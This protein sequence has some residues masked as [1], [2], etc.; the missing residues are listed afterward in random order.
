MKDHKDIYLFIPLDFSWGLI[1]AWGISCF[2]LALCKAARL[3]LACFYS[4]CYQHKKK[5]KKQET[6]TYTGTQTL[7]REVIGL[8]AVSGLCVCVWESGRKVVHSYGYVCVKVCV[9][10]CVWDVSSSMWT[11]AALLPPF[12]RCPQC[13]RVYTVFSFLWFPSPCLKHSGMTQRYVLSQ[14]CLLVLVHRIQ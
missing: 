6:L 11:A 5:T 14:V 8:S 4:H 12:P 10:V 3:L 9:C 13:L 7:D 1:F 2:R